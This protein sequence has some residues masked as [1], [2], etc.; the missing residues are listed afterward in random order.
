MANGAYI[1]LE[2]KNNFT[3]DG[4]FDYNGAMNNYVN[5]MNQ[6]GTQLENSY[7]GINNVLKEETNA[8]K[9]NT[10]KQYDSYRNQNAYELASNQRTLKEVMANNGLASSGDNITANT[11]L[12]NQYSSNNAKY[13]SDEA[14]AL[15]DIDLQLNK[16]L[17][18]N[19]LKKASELNILKQ[20]LLDKQMSMDTW[21]TEYQ[22]TLK[23]QEEEKKRWDL[24]WNNQLSQ[25]QWERE[26]TEKQYQ[27]SLANSYSSG[28]GSSSGYSG[29]ESSDIATALYGIAMNPNKNFDTRVSEL[30]A[31]KAEYN[32]YGD[33]SHNQYIDELI[34]QIEADKRYYTNSKAGMGGVPQT[35]GGSKP[36]N[37]ERQ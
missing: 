25:Q 10:V 35:I 32:A 13:N 31:K 11:S 7:N 5:Q 3:S 24:E 14:T 30:E 8:N 6:Q 36:N 27:A 28:S 19:D 34:N 4:S 23:Q 9:S 26:M 29:S 17:A 22:N 18:E 21:W 16:A 15:K 1:P 33:T 20:Q 2:Y 12:S 37:Y